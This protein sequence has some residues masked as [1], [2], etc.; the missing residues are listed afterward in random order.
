M[1]SSG[2]RFQFDAGRRRVEEVES[3]PDLNGFLA[4]HVAELEWHGDT[5]ASELRELAAFSRKL[6]P[7]GITRAVIG[8][9]DVSVLVFDTSHFLLMN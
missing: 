4:E 9:R 5:G 3:V 2:W 7:E 8:G 6:K 1:K